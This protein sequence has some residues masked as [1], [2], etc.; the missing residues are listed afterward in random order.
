MFVFL[1]KPIMILVAVAWIAQTA[2]NVL[3]VLGTA[4]PRTSYA[5]CAQLRA[6]FP[7]GLAATQA[8]ADAV[9]SRPRTAPRVFP[10]G[11]VLNMDLDPRQSGV[12]CARRDTLAAARGGAT[13]G[14]RPQ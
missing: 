9:S 7:T 12:V 14:E 3:P 2:W 13:P 11:Y 10:D 1:L 8:H 6:D 5:S 4:L